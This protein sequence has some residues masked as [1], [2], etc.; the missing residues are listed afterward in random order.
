MKKAPFRIEKIFKP[1]NMSKLAKREYIKVQIG[2][3]VPMRDIADEIGGSTR[4]VQ[5]WKG[6]R[7]VN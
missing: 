2:K 5:L 4:T 7:S 1:R 6:R 3:G